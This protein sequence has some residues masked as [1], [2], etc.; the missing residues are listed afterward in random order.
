M[1]LGG[2][3]FK[4]FDKNYK[5]LSKSI[6]AAVYDSTMVAMTKVSPSLV[7]LRKIDNKRF[8]KGLYNLQQDDKFNTAVSVG[9]SATSS[10]KLRIKK[11]EELLRKHL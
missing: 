2:L 8:L 3:A 5:P 9:T 6:N 10:V 4:V 7:K 11:I 1:L